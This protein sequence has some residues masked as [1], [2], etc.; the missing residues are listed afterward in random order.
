MTTILTVVG[1]DISLAA[2]QISLFRMLNARI[3]GVEQRIGGVEQRIGGVEQR[4]GGV[5]REVSNL[6]ERMAK[7]EGAVDGFMAGQRVADPA[8][9]GFTLPG[10]PW[11]WSSSTRA[12]SSAAVVLSMI[13]SPTCA[14]RSGSTASASKGASRRAVAASNFR[15]A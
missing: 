2:L 4:I 9:C 10:Q 15:A 13:Q 6:R 5:E 11:R 3:G 12:S 14:R 8:T 1:V 7:L